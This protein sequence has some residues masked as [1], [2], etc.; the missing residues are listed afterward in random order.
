MQVLKKEPSFFD[1]MQQIPLFQKVS[2]SIQQAAFADEGCRC[3]RFLAG[4]T[5]PQSRSVGVVCK[6]EL[7]AFRQSSGGDEILL[8]IFR[9]GGVFG[10]AGAFLPESTL[11][12]LRTRRQTDILFLELPL[13]QKLFRTNAQTAENYIAYLSGR[14]AFL[15]GRIGVISGGT[16]EQRLAMWLLS[17]EETAQNEILLPCSVANLSGL[18]GI[19]RASLYRVLDRLQ[20]EK[21]LE[22]HG[23][24]I[25]ILDRGGLT[26][27]LPDNGSI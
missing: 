20:Q 10:L 3:C 8:N 19:S 4:E 2:L 22:K 7:Q 13:L 17:R 15:A 9:K 27:F 26:D 12:L 1:Q 24:S 5:L 21:V 14:V 6:G 25:Q 16:A 11:S 23:H 18:L